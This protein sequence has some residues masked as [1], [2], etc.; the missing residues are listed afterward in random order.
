MTTITVYNNAGLKIVTPEP[1]AGDGG[2][3]LNDNFKRISS[4]M[5]GSGDGHTFQVLD[6]T[7]GTGTLVVGDR[8]KWFTN[9]GVP[10]G[11]PVGYNLPTT[12]SGIELSFA[13]RSSGN[14][15]VF[16]GATSRIYAGTIVSTTGGFISS[17]GVGSTLTLAGLGNEW[18]TRYDKGIWFI[19]V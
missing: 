6:R 12:P 15:V 17:S 9:N 18:Y 7:T 1:V 10:S 4:H 14:L 8:G 5:V 3:A 16:A 13:V 11:L 2:Q 19:E